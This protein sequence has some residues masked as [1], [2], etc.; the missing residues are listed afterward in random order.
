MAITESELC[1]LVKTGAAKEFV[2]VFD[3]DAVARVFLVLNEQRVPIGSARPACRTFK[4]SLALVRCMKKIGVK[5]FATEVS[6]D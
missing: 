2:V 1:N 6:G 3:E 5:A 4:T